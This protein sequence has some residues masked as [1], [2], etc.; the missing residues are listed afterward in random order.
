VHYAVN[1]DRPTGSTWVTAQMMVDGQPTGVTWGAAFTGRQLISFSGPLA[2]TVDLGS[3][4]VVSART[5]VMRLSDPRFGPLVT[6]PLPMAGAASGAVPP[7]STPSGPDT[8]VTNV[9]QPR[10]AP[11]GVPSLG[12]A[13]AW[14]VTTETITSAVLVRQPLTSPN[15][16]VIIVPVYQLSGADHSTWQVIAVADSGLNFAPRRAAPPATLGVVR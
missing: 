14:P 9:P 1:S 16:A 11:P 3:F 8:P 7:V 6:G 10:S 2:P 15:G 12:A 5:A 13:I 4:P